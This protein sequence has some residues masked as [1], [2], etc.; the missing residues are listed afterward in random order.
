MVVVE[1]SKS[2]MVKERRMAALERV[3]LLVP[4][5][6]CHETIEA[7]VSRWRLLHIQPLGHIAMFLKPQDY[8]VLLDCESDI[9]LLHA[10]TL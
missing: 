3:S 8:I 4:R 10:D 6:C 9:K 1:W 2:G 5:N 7:D